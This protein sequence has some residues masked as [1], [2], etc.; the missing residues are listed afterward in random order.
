MERFEQK[1]FV[2]YDRA[3]TLDDL[4]GMLGGYL[5]LFMG[6]ALVQV[7][8]MISILAQWIRNLRE[9][10]SRRKEVGNEEINAPLTFI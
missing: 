7:P 10:K 3:Y 1:Y 9:R 2:S 5:G 6:C 8:K 4:V